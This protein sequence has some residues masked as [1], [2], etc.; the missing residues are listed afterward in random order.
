MTTLKERIEAQLAHS[1]GLRQTV[2]SSG[3]ASNR[4]AATVALNLK[5]APVTIRAESVPTLVPSSV[6]VDLQRGDPEP[7]FKLQAIKYPVEG[8][9]VYPSA[10]AI[11]TERFFESFL[12]VCRT[13]PIPGSKRGHE[14]AS[15]PATDFYLVGGKLEKSGNGKGTVYLK[16][17]VPPQGDTTSNVGL[18]RDM[19]AGIVHFSIVTRPKYETVDGEQRFTGSAGYERNDAVEYGTGA[20]DQSTNAD[21]TD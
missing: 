5:A 21:R 4:S 1:R 6:M 20:M 2:E 12:G 17:Y 7:Y 8:S 3:V 14:P 15:R 16:N 18:I 9:G 13:R 19:K 11:Y 10:K